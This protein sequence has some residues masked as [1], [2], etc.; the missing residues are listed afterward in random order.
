MDFPLCGIGTGFGLGVEAGADGGAEVPGRLPSLSLILRLLL[1]GAGGCD[2]GGRGAVS[3]RI[4]RGDMIIDD[5]SQRE[6]Y[7]I[8]M[9]ALQKE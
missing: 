1:E 6:I 5:S 9:C 3:L 2:D 7:R 8:R 4:C